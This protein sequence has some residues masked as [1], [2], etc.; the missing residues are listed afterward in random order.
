M[1]CLQRAGFPF[2]C[3]LASQI[4]AHNGPVRKY[5]MILNWIVFPWF[6]FSHAKN[7]QK[8]L[9]YHH[10]SMGQPIFLRDFS[11]KNLSP[12]QPDQL[13][14]PE[15][16]NHHIE[17]PQIPGISASFW[18]FCLLPAQASDCSP[19]T[20]SVASSIENRGRPND[21]G[22]EFATSWGSPPHSHCG[23]NSRLLYR[24]S[25]DC[26]EFQDLPLLPAASSLS[27]GFQTR[28]R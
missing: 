4:F 9:L 6:T 15:K 12:N 13:C 25:H 7:I 19:S 10:P 8:S 5:T 27:Q 17:R 18:V 1:T 20:M 22:L 26:F 21:W 2:S 3:A 28:Q 14:G 24:T 16:G 11:T 23:R